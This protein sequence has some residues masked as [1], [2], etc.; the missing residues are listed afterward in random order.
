MNYKR[1]HAIEKRIE[2]LGQ[3]NDRR[4]RANE[5][6]D[7]DELERV[8]AEYEAHQMNTMARELRMA[9]MIRKLG[10][11]TKPREV[12]NLEQAGGK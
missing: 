8:A 1:S 5:A 11:R 12:G 7:L 3:L 4:L 10:M 9:I 2:W 6:N